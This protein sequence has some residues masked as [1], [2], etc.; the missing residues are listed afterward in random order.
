MCMLRVHAH[1]HVHVC[2]R[3][4]ICNL[5]ERPLHVERVDRVVPG[6]GYGRDEVPI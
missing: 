1:V 4:C 2:V 6:Q 3:M 5:P